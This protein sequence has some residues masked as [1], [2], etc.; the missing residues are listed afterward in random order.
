[1]K[2]VLADGDNPYSSS[3]SFKVPSDYDFCYR[4]RGLQSEED[5]AMWANRG[6]QYRG[7]AR[8][9]T[10]GGSQEGSQG[11]DQASHAQEPHQAEAMQGVFD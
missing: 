10:G 7:P 5:A 3:A 9:Y 2:L 11:A 1:M 6:G 8:S 4:E